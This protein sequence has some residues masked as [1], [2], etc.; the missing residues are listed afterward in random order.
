MTRLTCIPTRNKS[1]HVVDE[2]LP[3]ATGCPAPTVNVSFPVPALTASEANEELLFLD[4]CTDSKPMNLTGFHSLPCDNTSFIRLGDGRDFS[5]H[6]IQ[7]GVPK[8]CLF[9]VVPIRWAPG[10]NGEDDY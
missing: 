3:L 5:S 6:G 9:V 4:K 8:A 10:G 2:D 1:V 7:G